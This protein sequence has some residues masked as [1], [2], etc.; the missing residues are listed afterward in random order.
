MLLLVF[1]DPTLLEAI[2]PELLTD[3]RT[4]TISRDM[5]TCMA[6]NLSVK[7]KENLR[8]DMQHT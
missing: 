4:P 1:F 5:E 3:E 2:D 7:T 6:R 8:M